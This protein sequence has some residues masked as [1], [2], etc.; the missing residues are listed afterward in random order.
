MIEILIGQKFAQLEMKAVTARILQNFKLELA[1]PDFEPILTAEVVLKSVNG[2]N[3]KLK[4][5][6]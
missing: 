6:N 2:I 1:D 4:S 5:R 3:I